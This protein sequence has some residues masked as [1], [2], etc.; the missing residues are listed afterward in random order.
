MITVYHNPRCTKSRD[1]V[2]YLQENHFNYET[3]KYLDTPL[4]YKEIE[5]LVQNSNLKPID[6]IRTKEPIWIELFK[7]KPLS[8]SQII[9]AMADY[10]ILIERPIVVIDKKVIIVR[11]LEN[12]ISVLK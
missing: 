2:L 3:I 1:C 10:P 5:G 7:N 9:Q 11:P 6:F 4:S 12:L 8:D